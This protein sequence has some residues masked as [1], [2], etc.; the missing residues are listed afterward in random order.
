[1][2]LVRSLRSI[3][4]VA[5]TGSALAVAG[6][7]VFGWNWLR[8]PIERVVLERTGRQLAIGGDLEF[9]FGWPQPRLRVG[10]VSFSNPDWATEK[11][12]VSAEAV[13]LSIDLLQLLR[14]KVV[15]PEIRLTRPLIFLEQGS[16]GRK[17]W[18]LDSHQ[19]DEGARIRIDRL[20]LDRGTLGYDDPGQK[21]RLRLALSTLGGGAAA[22]A[23]EGVIFSAQGR[24]QGLPL[25]ASGRGG[26][27][28]ALRDEDTPYPLSIAL[29][30]GPT[31]LKADGSITGLATFAALD[32]RLALSGES[33]AQLYP[34]LGIAFP[35]T[36]AYATSGRLVHAG[37]VWRYEDFSGRIGASDIAGQ[38][39][40]D[41]GGRRPALTA[42]LLSKVLDFA[43]L[44]PLIGARPGS[45][46]QAR[47]AAPVASAAPTPNAARVLPELPFSS[48][49]WDSVD[50]EVSLKASSIRSAEALSLADFS[51]HLSLRDSVLTLAP[52][53]F[54]VA[55]G[56]LAGI[57]SLDGRASPIA[58]RVQ[59][60]ARKIELAQLFPDDEVS[61]S[62]IGQ[63]NGEFDLA[64]TGNSVRSMLASS[65]G[66]VGLVVRRGEISRLMMER[67]GLHLWEIFEL[68]VAGDQLVE[69]RCAVADFAVT[70]GAMNAEALVFDTAVTTILGTGSIDLKQE[71]LALTLNQKTKSTS[72]LA[73]R[74]PILVRGTFAQPDIGVAKGPVAARAFAAVALAMVNPLLALLPLIDAGPGSDSDCRQLVQAA[75]ALP[76]APKKGPRAAN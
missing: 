36:P 29:R 16:N 30:I 72:P 10:A 20:A 52:L 45:V 14:L 43:D 74:S 57:L 56:H 71:K 67:A 35:E 28:L 65:N 32:M 62:S 2:T 38:L 48:E 33:L 8:S 19:Q 54:G 70:N 5:L 76:R 73:V 13:E 47:Q 7:A 25:K 53:D 63:I 34:L 11:L 40:I 61:Q 27:V 42:D 51:T 31:E 21:T 26:A 75:R 37:K 46:D 23:A 44:G 39:Q 49:H 9:S 24:Y 6:I 15:F 1:M 59:L 41:H 58:A 3:A 60:R 17:N 66:K 18:L 69:L 12:M 55:G 4:V 22:P 68:N 64:G 50:A